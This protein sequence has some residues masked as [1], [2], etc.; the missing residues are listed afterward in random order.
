MNISLPLEEM[1]IAEKLQLIGTLWDDLESR[2]REL[3]ADQWPL[4]ELNRRKAALES[5]EGEIKDWSS[6]KAS[7]LERFH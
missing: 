2:P 7:L 4:E 1:T 5:G 3:L 6:V